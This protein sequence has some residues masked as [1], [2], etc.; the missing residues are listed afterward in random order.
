M[1]RATSPTTY[2]SRSHAAARTSEYVFNH[3]IPYIGNKRKLLDLIAAAL[4][5][6]GLRPGAVF[7]D[8]FA[9]SGVVGRLAKTQG[10]S[11][12]ANDWEPY[13]RVINSCYIACEAAPPFRALGGYANAI[14]TLNSLPPRVDWVTEHLCP[15]DDRDYDARTERMFYM[16]KNGQRIDAMRHQ[17]AVW[18]SAGDIDQIEE[19]CLLAPLLYQA[20]YTSN[21]SGVFKGFHNGWG[22]R[23]GTAL[24]RIASNLTLSPAVFHANG[25][26][27]TV[28]CDDAQRV[29]EMLRD[30]PVDVAYLDPP[31]NQ[32]PYGSNYHVLNSIA[33]WD[34][35]VLSRT[36]THGT[37][38][39]IRTDWRS[40]RRSLYNH[41]DEAA[42][43]YRQLIRTLN[44]HY[45][46]TSYSTDGTIPLDALLAANLECGQVRLVMRGYKRYRVST[47]RFSKKP[48]N[49]EFVVVL[50]KTAEPNA[51]VAELRGSILAYEHGVL[52][53]HAAR[54]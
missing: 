40:A 1:N 54:G 35:P 46:L 20:C 41:A 51:S 24:Y 23:T 39:A 2:V 34:Q 14:H 10:Y 37:K 19:D 44:A 22:G 31:Y 9:G 27:N 47:Q 28:L 8:L 21:T 26:S 7:L 45:I 18:R 6:L 15:C 49:V 30:T 52:Q 16:R 13:S 42:T 36:V 29:A 48:M 3:L 38:A 53:Q 12:I 11:V 32:H 43:A 33:L 17:V 50:D 25:Q 5:P 4:A